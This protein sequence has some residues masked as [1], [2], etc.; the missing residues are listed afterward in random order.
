MRMTWMACL[1][2]LESLAGMKIAA[3]TMWAPFIV[4]EADLRRSNEIAAQP[5]M[6]RVFR[7]LLVSARW[8]FSRLESAAF[9]VRSADGSLSAVLWSPAEEPDQARWIGPFPAGVVAIVHTHPNWQ[10]EPSRIDIRTAATARV[11][12]YVITRERIVK[13]SGGLPLLVAS[14]WFS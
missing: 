4:G 9:I 2:L 3:Q 12:V 7:E 10:P 13:T 5:E 11:P 14:R 6:L 1:M 8:G